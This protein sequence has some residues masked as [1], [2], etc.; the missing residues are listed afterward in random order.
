MKRI[1][2]NLT[3]I[4]VSSIFALL[5]VEG[6]L[7]LVPGVLPIEV[8][9][10]LNSKGRAHPEIG[11]L[12][13]PNSS[14]VIVT[15]DFESHYTVDENGF[16]NARSWPA[17]VDIVV[18]GDSL[19]FG[20]GVDAES[21]WPQVLSGYTGMDVLNLGLI[22]ASPQQYRKIYETFVRPLSPT[23]VVIGFFARNDFWDA[24]MY[25][26]WERS[27]VGGN[28]LEWR[29]FGRP[30]S[31]QF[32]NP[33]YRVVYALRKRSYVLALLKFGRDALSGRKATAPTELTLEDGSQILLHD[34]DYSAK[35]RLSEPGNETFDLVV[36]EFRQI[37]DAALDDGARLVV[38]LQPAK[39]EVYRESGT[40]PL[41]DATAALRSRLEQLE[42]ELIDATPA[43]R[44]LGEDGATLY[45]PTDGHPN[46]D[47]Y[48]E[49]ARLVAE[50]LNTTGEAVV[51]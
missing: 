39:E 8:R 19:V 12:P 33:L 29:G 28:Y 47:G 41:P 36:E 10:A 31:E 50:Y 46:A 16:R 9:Q 30:T 42:I 4:A 13:E 26:N 14:G 2:K 27:G 3:L 40:A 49:F 15:R 22:G 45:F 32:E 7:H 5:L 18:V 48:A 51:R 25:A 24:R 17:E 37:R 23:V 38:L 44:R 6:V 43:L 11:N 1:A 20:Y 34:M 21:A 35:T